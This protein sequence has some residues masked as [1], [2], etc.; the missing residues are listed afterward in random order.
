VLTRCY[1]QGGWTEEW[2]PLDIREPV[3]VEEPVDAVRLR[4]LR[5]DTAQGT[6]T[7]AADF[8]PVPAAVGPAGERPYYPCAMLVVDQDGIIV[9]TELLH[10]SAGTKERQEALIGCLEQGGGLP[11]EIVVPT[12][13]VRRL[14][15]PVGIALNV[16]TRIADLPSLEALKQD[17]CAHLM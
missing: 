8:F 14:I 5:L 6:E 3:L 17:L 4:R 1:R 16:S 2:R 12:D 10:P 11:R 15:E 7:W 9:G 13:T